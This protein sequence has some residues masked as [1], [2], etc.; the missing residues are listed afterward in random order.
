MSER[1]DRIAGA[2][3]DG[4]AVFLRWALCGVLTGLLMALGE[5]FFLSITVEGFATGGELLV[6]AGGLSSTLG[7]LGGVAGMALFGLAR[8]ASV[9]VRFLRFL[10]RKARRGR[11]GGEATGKSG[12]GSR[13]GLLGLGKV[14]GGVCEAL[15]RAW[16]ATWMKLSVGVFGTG[17]V[18]LG[19]AVNALAYHRLYA[20]YH[21]LLSGLTFLCGFVGVANLIALARKRMEL[22]QRLRLRRGLAATSAILVV[23]VVAGAPRLVTN[24]NLKAIVADRGVT[25]AHIY[26]ALSAASDG[27][28]DGFAPP[29]FGYDCDDSTGTR[30]PMRYD[31]PGN[32]KD[33]DCTG[34]DRQPPKELPAPP[35]LGGSDGGQK[36]EG[37]DGAGGRNVS[38]RRIIVITIDCLRADRW[39]VYAKRNVIPNIFRLS[40]HGF[41]FHRAYATSNWTVPSVYSV[42]T[43][44]YP[45]EVRFVKAMLDFD[46]NVALIDPESDFAQDESNMR[47]LI[48]VPGRDEAPTLAEEL[49]KRGYETA[50]I[51][52]TPFLKPE[53]GMARGFDIVD[54]SPYEK[55]N[56]S[57]EGVTAH[58]MAERALHHVRAHREELFFLYMHLSEPHAPY[59]KHPNPTDLGDGRGSLRLGA[60]VRRRQDRLPAR[61]DAKRGAFGRRLGGHHLGPRRGVSRPRRPLPRLDR[62]RGADSGPSRLFRSQHEEKADDPARI[63]RRH[64]PHNPLAGGRDRGPPPRL[65]CRSEQVA[66]HYQRSRE[67]AH[68]VD[69]CGVEEVRKLEADRGGKPLQADSR[70]QGGSLHALRP[71][72]GSRRDQKPHKQEKR[73]RQRAAR[74]DARLAGPVRRA[75]SRQPSGGCAVGEPLPVDLFCDPFQH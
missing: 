52:D 35:K 61:G 57:L 22:D 58:L 69:I 21:G 28:G 43:G 1:A 8:A 29:P 49:K 2:E 67:D 64:L 31:A 74:D 30:H 44:R 47:K 20:G 18:F 17:G 5:Y 75:V 15:R 13:K 26:F 4:S 7:V 39:P 73:P 56:R 46:D 12:K 6:F 41:A 66:S 37:T 51:L 36:K 63:A 48:P 45:F 10:A 55:A 34:G 53:M 70:Q 54:Q 50:T 25:S 23:G 59:H 9:S 33:E 27:D 40:T 60:Q 65:R 11:G 62:L 71:P 24:E 16:S 14:C 42:L 3:R 19:V 68:P 38:F 32:G 72:P